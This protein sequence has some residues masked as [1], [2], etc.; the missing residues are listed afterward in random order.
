MSTYNGGVL[1]VADGVSGWAEENVDPAVFA[2]ELMS[3]ISSAIG[4]D[5]V[6]ND[7]QLIVRMAHENTHSIGSATM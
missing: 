3:N 5:E 1:A 7:P 2:R 4:D 6:K